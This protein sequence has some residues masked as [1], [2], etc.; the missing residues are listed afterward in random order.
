MGV[1]PLGHLWT[2]AQNWNGPRWSC[3]GPWSC[4]AAPPMWTPCTRT[5]GCLVA[6]S[7]QRQ[8]CCP[9]TTGTRGQNC[10]EGR[11]QQ[12]SQRGLGHSI[13]NLGSWT[14]GAECS[15]SGDSRGLP[16]SNSGQGTPAQVAK[17]SQEQNQEGWRHTWNLWGR[18]QK[19]ESQGLETNLG[20]VSN[21]LC[22]HS[23]KEEK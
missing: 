19:R 5:G 10:T 11:K 15:D 18:R 7:P 1:A 20:Y 2:P 21:H 14:H 6:A 17:E 13:P 4:R 8:H 3:A 22:P 12:H 9:G 16:P 23:K